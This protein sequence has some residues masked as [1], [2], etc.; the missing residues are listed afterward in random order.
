MIR[1]LLTRPDPPTSIPTRRRRL[2]PDGAA[3]VLDYTRDDASALGPYDVVFDAVGR[4]KTSPLKEAAKNALT[5]TGTFISVDDRLPWFRRND[6]LRLKDFAEAGALKPA[7]DRRYPLERIAEAHRY[8][9]QGH[10][11]GNVVITSRLSRWIARVRYRR[12]AGVASVRILARHSCGVIVASWPC[13][14]AANT[15]SRIANRNG[16]SSAAFGRAASSSAAIF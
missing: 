5:P 13:S 11:K 7:I 10:K 4:R 8:V 3:T 1:S 2:R 6:L 16:N 9:E 15:S 12:R 14:V